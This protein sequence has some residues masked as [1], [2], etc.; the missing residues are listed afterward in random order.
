MSRLS[1]IRCA[2]YVAVL[3]LYVDTPLFDGMEV[4]NLF[5][6]QLRGLPVKFEAHPF[7]PQ[8]IVVTNLSL[9]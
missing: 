8:H 3:E 6:F 4:L 7:S 1:T 9:A 2:D 5:N